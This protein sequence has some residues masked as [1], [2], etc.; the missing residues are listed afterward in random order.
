MIAQEGLLTAEPALQPE[1]IR[2]S[3]HDIGKYNPKLSTYDFAKC[4]AKN[5]TSK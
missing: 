2:D 3:L 5:K 4:R 1:A